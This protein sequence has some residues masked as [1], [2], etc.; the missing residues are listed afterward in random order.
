MTRLAFVLPLPKHN[1]IRQTSPSTSNMDRS[2]TGKVESWQIVKPAIRIPCPAGDRAVHDCGPEK[3]KNQRREDTTTL[4]GASNDDLY[5]ACAEQQL[6]Q[7]EDDL[8]DVYLNKR[9]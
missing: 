7:T 1:S 8:G 5:C 2:A 6:V 3:A 4:K 9:V